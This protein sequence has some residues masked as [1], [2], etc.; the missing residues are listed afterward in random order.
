L[1]AVLNSV[2]T[3]AVLLNRLGRPLQQLLHDLLV[4]TGNKFARPRC[5]VSWR[6]RQVLHQPQGKT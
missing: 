5:P 1:F 2:S 3:L 4:F 6:S